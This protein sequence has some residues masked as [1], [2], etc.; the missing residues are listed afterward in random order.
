[1]D[2]YVCALYTKR[3]L[4]PELEVRYAAFYTLAH[5]EEEAVGLGIAKAKDEY[6]DQQGWFGH[7]AAAL[8]VDASTIQKAYESSQQ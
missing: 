8:K 4:L 2:L 3:M 6:P 1:M 7:S 5:S